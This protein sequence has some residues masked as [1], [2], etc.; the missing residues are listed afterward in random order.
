MACGGKHLI[1]TGTDG[2]LAVDAHRIKGRIIVAEGRLKDPGRRLILKKIGLLGF[3][4]PEIG[5]D[6]RFERMLL[7]KPCRESVKRSDRGLLEFTAYLLEAEIPK[8]RGKSGLDL[9]GR[10]IGEGKDQ[11]LADPG[12]AVLEDMEDAFNQDSRFTGPCAG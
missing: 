5:I 11:Q 4:H 7:Q 2:V 8:S 9:I 12:F 3:Q 1:E 6:P 10:F